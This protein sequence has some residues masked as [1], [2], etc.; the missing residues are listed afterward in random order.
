MGRYAEA[1]EASQKAH[2][3]D[4]SYPVIE[5]DDLEHYRVSNSHSSINTASGNRARNKKG[6]LRKMQQQ[7]RKANH[8]KR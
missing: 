3:L 8:K 2:L 6:H 5:I 4:A 7:S 1:V